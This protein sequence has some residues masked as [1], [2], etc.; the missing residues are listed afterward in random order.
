MVSSENGV[1]P[2]RLTLQKTHMRDERSGPGWKS[3]G[4]GTGRMA[5]QILS[6]FLF[7]QLRMLGTGVRSVSGEQMTVGELK[8]KLDGLDPDTWIVA[9]R[10]TDTLELFDIADA[11]PHRGTA[12]RYE[13]GKL[14]FA[15]GGTG[16]NTWLFLLL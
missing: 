6:P 11:S 13:N 15:S 9:Y 14:G 12:Q 8:K 10:E 5:G 2:P 4:K 16:P 7:Q 1:R 3:G